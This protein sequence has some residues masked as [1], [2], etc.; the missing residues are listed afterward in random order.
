MP[1][2]IFVV[3]NTS[4]P[5]K[6]CSQTDLIYQKLPNNNQQKY[7]FVPISFAIQ[8]AS[9]LSVCVCVCER[10]RERDRG[11]TLLADAA[12]LEASFLYGATGPPVTCVQSGESRT[13][14][15][16]SD[17]QHLA[18]TRKKGGG[19]GFLGAFDRL[20]GRGGQ[21]TNKEDFSKLV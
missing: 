9:S 8:F 13:G 11:R 10:E 18:C 7:M 17:S 19:W 12:A 15:A 6:S 21:L 1:C 16:S 5:E 2:L 3:Q 4:W 20:Q 14:R